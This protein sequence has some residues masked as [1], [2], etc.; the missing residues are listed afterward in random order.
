MFDFIAKGLL[1]KIFTVVKRVMCKRIDQPRKDT[2]YTCSHEALANEAL[3]RI[4]IPFNLYNFQLLKEFCVAFSH[5]K[6]WQKFLM[7]HGQNVEKG[8]VHTG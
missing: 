1:E 4:G 5:K 7:S 3:I 6:S 8:F 2:V